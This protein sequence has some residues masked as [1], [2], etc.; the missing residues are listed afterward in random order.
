[1]KIRNFLMIFGFFLVVI[2]SINLISAIDVCCEETIDGAWCVSVPEEQCASQNR[3]ATSCTETTYC[4]F[5]TCINSVKGECTTS[6]KAPCESEGLVWDDRDKDEIAACQNGCCIMGTKVAF[7]TQT[8]CKQVAS[9]YGLNSDFNPS[10]SE[11]E[12]LDLSLA[13]EEGACVTEEDYVTNCE[14]Y[15]TKETCDQKENSVFYPNLLCTAEGISNCAPTENTDCYD[16]GSSTKVF[17]KDSCGNKANVYDET[18]YSTK[19]NSWNPDMR[20]YWTEIQS[21]SCTSLGADSECGNCN[22]NSGSICVEYDSGEKNMPNQAPEYGDYVCSSMACYYDT[23]HDGEAEKY[24]H[25][26]SWC[27][28]TRGTY[29]HLPLYLTYDDASSDLTDAEERNIANIREELEDV[30]KYNTPGSR[31]VR[32]GCWDGEVKNYACS[33]Y[34]QEVCVEEEIVPDYSYAQCV[35]N[36]WR[37]CNNISTQTECAETTNL[38]KW[39]IGYRPAFWENENPK[40]YKDAEYNIEEQG[41]CVPLIPPGI[42]FWNP[43]GSGSAYCTLSGSISENVMYETHWTGIGIDRDSIQEDYKERAFR[44]YDNCWAIPDYG[45]KF[46]DEGILFE[47]DVDTDKIETLIKFHKGKN[48]L[49][50]DDY[51]ISDREGYYCKDGT[52]GMMGRLKDQR[53]Q[54]DCYWKNDGSKEKKKRA[55]IPIFYTNEQ[56][57]RQIKERTLA[58]GDCGYKQN[59]VQ[60]EG[61]ILSEI[62]TS[63]FSKLNQD[64]EVTSEKEVILLW[65]GDNWIEENLEEYTENLH[66]I[67]REGEE[68]NMSEYVF[69]D[70]DGSSWY[71]GP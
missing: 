63:Q 43:E 12:C 41:S 57:L 37:N 40:A 64:M 51:Y 65:A 33:D 52:T 56:W 39:V 27:A 66:G 10:L 22:Y 14:N 31:Y 18:M 26:E 8:E 54:V 24:D 61:D 19:D 7:V 58:L 1:M 68:P 70:D 9:E 69:T 71:G 48:W 46:L 25:G 55:Q 42:D 60:Q 45:K 5:G 20:D 53:E 32:L 44:C 36:P 11:T 47:N 28:E 49:D 34:R 23:N 30:E 4:K 6:T 16:E 13:E 3:A 38:C 35:T 59:F 17:F 67:V 62:I 21:A 50:T 15:I 2:S 29:H